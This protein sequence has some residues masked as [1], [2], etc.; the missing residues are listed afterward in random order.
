[1]TIFEQVQCVM[2]IIDLIFILLLNKH[3]IVVTTM[4][5]DVFCALAA[6][7][8]TFWPLFNENSTTFYSE[9]QKSMRWPSAKWRYFTS[10]ILNYATMN[11]KPLCNVYNNNK[12]WSHQIDRMALLHYCLCANWKWSLNGKFDRTFSIWSCNT[13]PIAWTLDAQNIYKIDRL[14][15]RSNDDVEWLNLQMACRMQTVYR[16]D[17]QECRTTTTHTL[18]CLPISLFLI[19]CTCR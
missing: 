3:E 16:Q 8:I 10:L 19:C 15:R 1:M 14:R 12:N 18:L 7:Q 9:Q 5:N 11:R 4:A 17:D 2:E 6:G 13:Y